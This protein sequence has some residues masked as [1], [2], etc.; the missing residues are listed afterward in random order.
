MLATLFDN[1]FIRLIILLLL[2][3]CNGL[4]ALAEVA[5]IS[6][7]TARLEQRARD[8]SRRAQKTLRI[9]ADPTDFLSTVQIGITLIG[10]VAGAFSGATLAGTF[11]TWLEGLG[12]SGQVASST[13][14]ILVVAFVTY[15]SLTVGEL[16]PKAIGLNNPERYALLLA[17]PLSYLTLVTMPLVRVLSLTTNFV[18]RLLGVDQSDEPPVTEEEVKMMLEQ[19]KEAGV[20][21]ADEQRLVHRA[22]ELDD[23]SMDKLMTREGS[24]HSLLL[25]DNRSEIV[26]KTTQHKHSY[27]PICQK[28]GETPHGVV[29]ASELLPLLAQTN[30]EE[31]VLESLVRKPTFLEVSEAPVE[32]IRAFRDS[33]LH[34]VFVQD[35]AQAFQGIVTPGNILES[36]V[37]RIREVG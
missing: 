1:V 32:A 18:I 17:P 15:L 29:R 13:S 16:I 27:Y 8:G 10:I 36:L 37:G 33:G 35:E 21:E 23:I 5:I 14:Y 20:F 7:R 9:V 31:V 24:V 2:I 30:E 4:F 12:I 25:S 34:I 19:G 6:A 11:A 3:L 22:L 26:A 28:D